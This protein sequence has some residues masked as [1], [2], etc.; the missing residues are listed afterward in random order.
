MLEYFVFP[1]VPLF[2]LNTEIRILHEVVLRFVNKA[3]PKLIL[4][5]AGLRMSE[6]SNIVEDEQVQTLTNLY[7]N[8]VEAIRLGN[9]LNG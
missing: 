9:H 1:K 8:A 4:V 3:M 7:I 2:L 6:N 5:Y